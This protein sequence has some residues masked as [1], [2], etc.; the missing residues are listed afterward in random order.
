[1]EF[2]QIFILTILFQLVVSFVGR[3]NRRISAFEAMLKSIN[4]VIG[5]RWES[6]LKKREVFNSDEEISFLQIALIYLNQQEDFESKKELEEHKKRVLKEY[7]EK[8][9][10]NKSSIC[11]EIFFIIEIIIAISSCIALI[12]IIVLVV[13]FGFHFLIENPNMMIFLVLGIFIL[14]LLRMR[15]NKVSALIPS[16]VD[17]GNDISWDKIKPKNAS[18]HKDIKSKIHKMLGENKNLSSSNIDR[19]SDPDLIANPEISFPAPP[20]ITEF[21]FSNDELGLK[22]VEADLK[23]NRKFHHKL[24]LASNIFFFTTVLGICIYS[25]FIVDENLMKL[26]SIGILLSIII[27]VY[28]SNSARKSRESQIALALF[29]SYVGE[30]KLKLKEAELAKQQKKK[31]E[32]TRK[33]YQNFRIGLNELWKKEKVDYEKWLKNNLNSRRSRYNTYWGFKSLIGGLFIGVFVYILPVISI[34]FQIPTI[35]A[36]LV[37]L[38]LLTKDPKKRY[39]RAFWSVLATFVTT[40]FIPNLILLTGGKL[41]LPDVFLQIEQSKFTG[42][43]NI[44]MIILMVVLLLLDFKERKRIES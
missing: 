27:G 7:E 34:Q 6:S 36:I 23:R 29:T 2:F 13:Q 19:K 26:V 17:S 38:Y 39:M 21:I 18:E 43:I 37:F 28:S 4:K 32:L 8:N 40:N 20:G 35:A 9:K 44:L 5:K 10:E 11:K 31:R 15:I 12:W 1:M 41:I 22:E 14:F 16:I 33:A 24:T 30:L 42:W 25:L 3:H